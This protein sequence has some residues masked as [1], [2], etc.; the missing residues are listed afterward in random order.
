[1]RI[2][3]V[4]TGGVGGVFGA[5]LAAS[6]CD[7]T[8]IARGAH[9]AKIQEQGLTILSQE[10]GDTVIKP[11]NATDQTYKI[12]P[13]D[14]VL[15]AVKLWDTDSAAQMLKPLVEKHTAVISLQNGILRDEV[16]RR[17]VDP[18]NVVGGVSYIAAFIKEPGVI[19]QKGGVQKL[20]FGEYSAH[21]SDRLEKLRS[22]C[23]AAGIMAE[24]PENILLA[25]WEKF[26]FL[27]A[28]SAVTAA[29]RQ[30]IGPVRSNPKT[31]QLLVDV[32]EEAIAVAQARGVT[33]RQDLIR[34]KLAYWDSAAPDVTSSMQHDLQHGNRLEL[35]WL[36]GTL[37]DLGEELG[38]P[39][40]VNKT[41]VGVLSP[42]V[43]GRG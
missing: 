20:V 27:C 17:Y 30:T 8:F 19:E 33:I 40:P 14:Y 32:M 41:L 3:I 9:L 39:T 11:A 36:S 22:A 38:V 24:T 23:I 2:A 4:G 15:F 26:V 28:M 12:G 35:P 6:G 31:R 29:T 13:V 10:Y 16:V 34:E 1:M 37:V 5:R 25:I 21:P 42:F 18:S 43:N 7:V